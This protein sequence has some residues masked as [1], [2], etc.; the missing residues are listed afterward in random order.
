MF[1]LIWYLFDPPGP[2]RLAPGRAATNAFFDVLTGLFITADWIASNTEYFPYHAADLSPEEYLAE[3]GKLALSALKHMGWIGWQPEATWRTFHEIFLHIPAPNSVQQAVFDQFDSLRDP[4]L[5]ILEA[6]TGSGKTEAA[7]Y[8][9]D[10]WMQQQKLHG[11]Y[12]AM[13]TQATSNQMFE[14]VCE[15]LAAAFS[16]TTGKH[17]IGSRQ[18]LI[19]YR[20]QGNATGWY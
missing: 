4:F 5:M 17:S 14:R 10:R 12:V 7:L 9:A 20:I 13:P 11:C 3:A 19:E 1:D 16:E 6:P 8:I 2:A 18:C 15:Y